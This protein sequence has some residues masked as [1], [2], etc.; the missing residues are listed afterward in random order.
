MTTAQPP[1]SPTLA[2]A[3]RGKVR[4]YRQVPGG[5]WL[6]NSETEALSNVPCA[7]RLVPERRVELFAE[8]AR[9]YLAGR[10]DGQVSAVA[11]ARVKARMH[12]Q[13]ALVR[14]DAKPGE[15]AQPL[16]PLPQLADEKGRVYPLMVEQLV[17][18]D[19]VDG[20]LDRLVDEYG[21]LVTTETPAA[22]SHAKWEEIVTEGKKGSALKELVSRHGSSALI[23]VLHGTDDA[24]WAR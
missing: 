21:I 10:G 14:P 17:L 11:H 3:E 24:A 4:P 18:W 12:L 22:L 19:L 23:Q 15:P 8:L 2:G 5:I 9:Q 20:Q 6:L 13:Y 16:Y 7:L 1:S